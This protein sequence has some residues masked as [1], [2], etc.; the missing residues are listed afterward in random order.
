MTARS[1]GDTVL[2][3]RAARAARTSSGLRTTGAC[4]RAARPSLCAGF[5]S[6]RC[7]TRSPFSW[8]AS[9]P[10]CWSPKTART[11]FEQPSTGCRVSRRL[12]WRCS[13]PRSRCMRR[14]PLTTGAE[15]RPGLRDREL[16]RHRDRRVHRADPAQHATAGWGCR[17]WPSGRRCSPSSFPTRPRKAA[18]VTLAS[19]SARPVV[20]GVM[21]ATR[22][23]DI[24]ARSRRRSFS[25][26]CCRTCSSRSWRTS[27]RA[28][29]TRSARR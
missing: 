11:C 22:P 8:P 13:S 18:L 14:C 10:A 9:F 15:H 23:D 27:A 29:S 19:V 16:L 17:G 4:A 28:S 1:P 26:S 12:R 21:I 6:W 25:G 3:P 24:P 7:C 2:L 5:A 20:I